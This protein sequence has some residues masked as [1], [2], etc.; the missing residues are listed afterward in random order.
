MES[1][2]ERINNGKFWQFHGGVHPPEQK[3]LSNDK[4][5]RPLELPELLVLPLQQHIG[6]AAKLSVDVGDYVLK[7]QPL[8]YS[9]MPMAVPVHAPTSGTIEKIERAT[10]PHPSAMQEP[11]IYLK[12][13]G[14]DKWVERAVCD[15]FYSLSRETIIEK[16]A[17]AGISGM[18]GA[19]FPTHIKVNQK[20]VIDFLVINAAECEP[21]IT[22]DDLLM[23]EHSP[24][25]IDGIKILDHLLLPGHILIG[26]EDNK[27][28]AIRAL[29]KATEGY[30]KVRVCVLPTKYPTG[31]EKQLIKALTG[32]EVP[33]GVIPGQMG[34]VMQ[35]VA[36]CYAIADAVI[37]DTPLI[38][39]VVTVTGQSL[40]KPQNVWALLG[41]PVEFLLSQCG[42]KE[43]EN[44]MLVMGGPMMGFTLP[45]PK[46]PI[47]K[48]SNCVLAP[49][50]KEIP[51]PSD[52][53]ECIRC[54][55]CADVCPS[56][57]L[58]QELQWS[59]K[60]K[61]YEQLKKLNLFDCIDC[62]A[63][64]FV[65]PSQIPLVQYY[66]VAK[67]EI[68]F[69]QVQ[70]IKADK[71]KARF[72]ARK[73]RLEREKIAREE[74]HRK[75]AEARRAKMNANTQEASQAKS[76][77]AAAL[78]RVKAK[79]GDDAQEQEQVDN[80]KTEQKLAVVAAVA[81]AK[82]KKEAKAAQENTS[83]S[84]SSPD[85]D[86]VAVARA[87]AKKLAKAQEADTTEVQAEDTTADN[88]SANDK[89]ARV[90]AAVA[91][92]KAKKKSAQS[93]VS[94]A[95]DTTSEKAVAA[96]PKDANEKDDKK[97]RIATTVAKAKAKKQSSTDIDN[98]AQEE[99]TK[100]PVQAVSATDDKKARVAAAIAKAKAKKLAK[101][102]DVEPE[103]DV[104]ESTPDNSVD[105]KKA[106]I[107][108][109]IAKAKAKKQQAENK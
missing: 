67:A 41:T 38:K 52:E 3:W 85:K 60:A 11:C 20:P 86:R 61:D 66:R 79:K 2:I 6:S 15:D 71:A 50:N 7:G 21:Y 5:I 91:K 55:Q 39:R 97:A 107:A 98:P 13:D 68:R 4:P 1:I 48:T 45:S 58:P 51:T 31:G 62:G 33:A 59:A 99:I 105:D 24:S 9:H 69:Q 42:Y 12:P 14:K 36:T 23:R 77:V 84:A 104:N 88:S 8:T 78:A 34:I 53:Q 90:A 74:K 76:A 89:K 92:A 106:R 46:I 22:S 25:I 72:E 56:H 29:Q 100:E 82:A 30:D 16:I 83:S 54:G 87:K 101:A 37:N 108:A 19:G 47:I 27:P 75:A 94:S 109:A 96:K 44:S 95:S 93:A 81:R 49:S 18:G 28:E 10:I 35:N 63:C 17:N 64:A 102:T 40:E 32:K 73:A 43:A 57:L 70:E 26:I 65:C 80:T 103:V